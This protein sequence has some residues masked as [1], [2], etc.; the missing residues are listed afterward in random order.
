VSFKDATATPSAKSWDVSKAEWLSIAPII[1]ANYGFRIR[2]TSHLLRH[3]DILYSRESHA[4]T[5]LRNRKTP[6]EDLNQILS[7]DAAEA[8]ELVPLEERRELR[9]E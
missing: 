9:G 7:R 5:K 3:R 4:D 8:H 6:T 2:L 1:A